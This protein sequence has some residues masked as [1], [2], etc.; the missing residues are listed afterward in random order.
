MMRA[1]LFA[2][3]AQVTVRCCPADD[4]LSGAAGIQLVC[5]GS[6]CTHVKVQGAATPVQSTVV[7]KTMDA[8]STID[9]DVVVAKLSS[10]TFEATEAPAAWRLAGKRTEP[11]TLG[12]ITE[13]RTS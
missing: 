1:L 2:C 11:N 3:V 5:V 8:R 10:N 4:E 6:S 7:V 9:A 13:W 12:G